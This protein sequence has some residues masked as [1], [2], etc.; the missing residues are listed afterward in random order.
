MFNVLLIMQCRRPVSSTGAST[1]EQEPEND[2]YMIVGDFSFTMITSAEMNERTN[3]Y[4][5]LYI[6]MLKEII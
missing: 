3:L 5:W 6:I 1:G 2:R 4:A